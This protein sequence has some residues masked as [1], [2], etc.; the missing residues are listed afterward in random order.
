MTTIEKLEQH[1]AIKEIITELKK[2]GV[3]DPAEIEATLI[4]ADHI[5]QTTKDTAA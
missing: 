3:T 4:L 1:P 2:R 5:L